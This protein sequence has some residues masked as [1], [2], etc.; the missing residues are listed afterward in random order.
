M[1][2]LTSMPFMCARMTR[3]GLSFWC[4]TAQ[5]FLAS[6]TTRETLTPLAVDPAQPPLIMSIIRTPFEKAGHWSKSAETK[7]VVESEPTW[8]L[9]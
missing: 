1:S 7:P 9:A 5:A 2:P 8:K 6:R 3:R 4:T